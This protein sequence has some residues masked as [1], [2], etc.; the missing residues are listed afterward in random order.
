MKIALTTGGN[1]LESKVSEEFEESK[2]LLI[3]E[4]DDLSFNFYPYDHKDPVKM[5]KK[6]IECN[7]E[8]VITGSIEEAA[9]EELATAQVTRYYGSNYNA[10]EALNLMEAYKLDYIRDYKGGEGV[11]MH[12]HHHSCDCGEHD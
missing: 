4:T 10:R 7:C 6:I 9:F 12:H 3:V 8:A 5:A 1:T 11:H 2:Y